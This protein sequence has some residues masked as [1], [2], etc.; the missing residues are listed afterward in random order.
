MEDRCGKHGGRG[1]TGCR[2]H[3]ESFLGHA[4]DCLFM[5]GGVGIE[6]L[7]KDGPGVSGLFAVTNAEFVFGRRVARENFGDLEADE[8]ESDCDQPYALLLSRCVRV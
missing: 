3:A 1:F 7:V 4:I 2:D 6:D 8:L 5:F